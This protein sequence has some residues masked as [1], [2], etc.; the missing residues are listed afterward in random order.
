MTEAQQQQGQTLIV[1]TAVARAALLLCGWGLYS[2]Q[3]QP[4]QDSTAQHVTDQPSTA[5]AATGSHRLGS[6]TTAQPHCTPQP[7]T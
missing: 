4:E 5:N 7:A 2:A 6:T 1:D 3:G